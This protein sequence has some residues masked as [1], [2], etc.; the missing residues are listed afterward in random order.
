MSS[1]HKVK[2]NKDLEGKYSRKSRNKNMSGR[3]T[4]RSDV[5]GRGNA[6]EFRH[7]RPVGRPKGQ[8]FVRPSTDNSRTRAQPTPDP[9]PR[10]SRRSRRE[11]RGRGASHILSLTHEE[12]SFVLFR[13]PRKGETRK[14]RKVAR[15]TMR[16]RGDGDNKGSLRTSS[17][18][19]KKHCHHGT[20]RRNCCLPPLPPIWEFPRHQVG[21]SPQVGR[22]RA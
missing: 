17:R 16:W 20:Y 10:S 21:G 7:R 3:V 13:R 15:P 8:S 11:G 6:E 2:F 14:L 22:G 12:I 9:R 18:P 5:E 19:S 4:K 1:T